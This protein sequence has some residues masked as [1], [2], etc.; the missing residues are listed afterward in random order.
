MIL[1]EKTATTSRFMLFFMLVLFR[2][3]SNVSEK[4]FNK[5]V[6]LLHFLVLVAF[7]INTRT[8]TKIELCT[9]V[10]AD[11]GWIHCSWSREPCARSC[12]RQIINGGGANGEFRCTLTGNAWSTKPPKSPS[13]HRI[14]SL[15]F[16]SLGL[17]PCCKLKLHTHLT[18][19]PLRLLLLFRLHIEIG[20]S[21]SK[22]Q[23]T[24]TRDRQFVIPRTRDIGGTYRRGGEHC[25]SILASFSIPLVNN[26][27]TAAD[28]DDT[29]RETSLLLHYSLFT[30][31]FSSCISRFTFSKWDH[32]RSTKGEKLQL[33]VRYHINAHSIQSSSAPQQ[34]QFDYSYVCM[35]VCMCTCA[36]CNP[37][38]S[39]L[40]LRMMYLY[41]K[42]SL[43]LFAVSCCATSWPVRMYVLDHAS[44]ISWLWIRAC[45]YRP[46]KP[47][48]NGIIQANWMQNCREYQAS[49]QY[50]QW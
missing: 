19:C 27:Y 50:I 3:H 41:S 43:R 33:T 26:I 36:S 23:Y 32:M 18:F 5:G 47:I 24:A 30:C 7:C 49:L 21:I 39:F 1:F 44:V 48:S 16:S 42:D 35:Y 10:C 25:L 13:P 40:K 17:T 46:E 14:N 11:A 12:S 8:L 45:E 29:D 15:S 37:L 28:D 2:Q 31:I 38:M 20:I 34:A 9:D 6:F 22:W 4:C